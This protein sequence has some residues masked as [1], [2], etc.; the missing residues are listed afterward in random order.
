MSMYLVCIL[1]VCLSLRGVQIATLKAR[2]DLENDSIKMTLVLHDMCWFCKMLFLIGLSD[3]FDPPAL[4]STSFSI[5][6]LSETIPP[7]CL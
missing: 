3:E 5:E 7:T 2:T 1:L 6:E 4:L